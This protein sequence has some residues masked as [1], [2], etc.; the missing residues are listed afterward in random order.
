MALLGID[1]RA[2]VRPSIATTT[3]RLLLLSRGHKT[4]AR[5]KRALKLAPH[6]SFL[7]DRS[8]DINDA[9]D[10]IIYNPPAS[11]ASPAHTPFIFLP[12]EDPRRKALREVRRVGASEEGGVGHGKVTLPPSLR[13]RQ[14]E[15]KYHLNE[16]AVLEMRRLRTEDPIKWSVGK[17]AKKFECSP[18]FVTMVA[19]PPPG[20]ISWLKEK[21]ARKM[22]RWGPIKTK[23]REDRKRRSEML[24][25]GEL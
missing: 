13:W 8:V 7:P 6:D 3:S 19:P 2:L 5:T 23:A 1:L 14:Q 12:H 9:D 17:I 24:Y 11:E 22:A 4:T 16:E 15:Q 20:H 18:I 21:L 25:R 10:S